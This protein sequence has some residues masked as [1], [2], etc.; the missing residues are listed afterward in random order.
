MKNNIILFI[1]ILFSGL[2][3][4]DQH[5]ENIKQQIMTEIEALSGDLR[6]S[7]SRINQLRIG[8]KDLEVSLKNMED[9][10]KREQEDK[11]K[12]YNDK[13]TAEQNLN[14]EKAEHKVTKESY[15]R[16]KN[17]VG[18][19]CAGLFVFAYFTILAPGI[20]ELAPFLGHWGLLVRFGSPAFAAFLGYYS[21]Q[22]FF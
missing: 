21:A 14:K 12:Y 15:Y 4:A 18:Y 1:L 19:L 17:L 6:S 8:K 13:I 10:G 11:L 16:L 3:F 22:I 9:W 5:K 2:C 20:K 7:Q